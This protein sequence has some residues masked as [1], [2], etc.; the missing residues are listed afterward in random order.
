MTIKSKLGGFFSLWKWKNK[1]TKT[2]KIESKRIETKRKLSITPNEVKN[3]VSTTILGGKEEE[4]KEIEFD[5]CLIEQI[6]LPEKPEGNNDP[7]NYYKVG[8]KEK[9][10]HKRVN[11]KKI[12]LEWNDPI[13]ISSK[14]INTNRNSIGTL[15]N[16]SLWGLQMSTSDKNKIVGSEQILNFRVWIED[17]VL[18][19]IIK[20]KIDSTEDSSTL[21]WIEFIGLSIE[22]TKKMTQLITSILL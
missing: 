5:P 10:K 18:R 7:I 2:S 4:S 14:N 1:E 13:Y 6:W 16:L 9:R 15:T 22:E 21:Y 11:S 12:L 20:S 19:W 3:R 17:F 8:E